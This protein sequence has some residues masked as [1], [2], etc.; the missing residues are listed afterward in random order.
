MANAE[1]KIE[2][3]TSE[4]DVALAKAERLKAL[5]EDIKE[6]QARLPMQIVDQP[7]PPRDWPVSRAG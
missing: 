7:P 2:M 5:L 1:F 4:L 6:L 3:D